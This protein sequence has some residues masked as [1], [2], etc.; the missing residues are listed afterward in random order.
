MH[1][2]PMDEAWAPVLG[3]ILPADKGA[4]WAWTN[5][6]PR[7]QFR[8][9]ESSRWLFCLHFA[10][11]GPVLKVVGPQTIEIAINGAAVKT[12]S[13]AEPREYDVRFPIDPHSVSR[14]STSPPTA[15]RSAFC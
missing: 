2:S 9:E 14:P 7:L 5:A 13:A 8:M 10:A 4:E 1:E 11:V 6:R 15:S 12:V 3:G